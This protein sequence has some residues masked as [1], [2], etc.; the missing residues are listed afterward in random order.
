MSTNPPPNIPSNIPQPVAAYLQRLSLWAYEEINRAVKKNEAEPHLILAAYDQKQNP[1]IFR[2][3]VTNAGALEA[4]QVPLG[5]GNQT[6][7]TR[8][9]VGP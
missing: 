9:V 2:V 5:G 4:N 1:N 8:A 3:E 6:P 7:G